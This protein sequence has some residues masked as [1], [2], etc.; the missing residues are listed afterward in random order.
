M[1]A[2][3]IHIDQAPQLNSPT[4]ACMLPIVASRLALTI[5]LQVNKDIHSDPK[6]QASGAEALYPIT[7]SQSTCGG[8][9]PASQPKHSPAGIDLWGSENS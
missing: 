9:V 7:H 6:F 4:L 2:H 1:G 3:Q 8:Y 5:L